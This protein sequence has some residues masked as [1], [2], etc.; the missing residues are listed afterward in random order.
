MSTIVAPTKTWTSR[1]SRLVRV[2]AVV[3]AL[4]LGIAGCTEAAPP[5]VPDDSSAGQA[6]PS[7]SAA[8]DAAA[9]GTADPSEGSKLPSTCADVLAT[10]E[11]DKALGKQL[12]GKTLFIEGEAEPKIGRLGRVTCSYGVKKGQKSPPV[13]ATYFLYETEQ[14]A[15]DRVE[16]A[17]N[18]TRAA[19]N[20]TTDIKVGL[21][22][23]TLLIESKQITLVMAQKA[24]TYSITVQDS[25]LA[26]V[27]KGKTQQAVIAMAK[28]MRVNLE[29]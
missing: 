21:V 28:A 11:V 1:R 6:Q 22:P 9:S 19:G 16:S 14:D 20:K 8:S 7:G 10:V 3:T 27:N 2:C 15:S 4:G 18:S 25:A 5:D 12:D 24:T 17:V 13:L 26:I 23:A 29:G